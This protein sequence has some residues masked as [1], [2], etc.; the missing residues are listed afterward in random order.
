LSE[1]RRWVFLANGFLKWICLEI[2]EVIESEVPGG[3]C[4]V[5]LGAAVPGLFVPVNRRARLGGLIEID[6]Q[7]RR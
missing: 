7:L 3:E 1:T 4:M 2:F 5:R 6:G